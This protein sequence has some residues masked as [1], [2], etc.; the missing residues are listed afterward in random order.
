M[1][2]FSHYVEL[3]TYFV[4]RLFW[5]VE[6]TFLI[7]FAL[8]KWRTALALPSVLSFGTVSANGSNDHMRD[9]QRTL[10]MYNLEFTNMTEREV[11]WHMDV[12]NA[13]LWQSVL[14]CFCSQRISRLRAPCCKNLQAIPSL[15]N[16]NWKQLTQPEKTSTPSDS[17]ANG[18]STGIQIPPACGNEVTKM[19]WQ[20]WTWKI[21]VLGSLLMFSRLGLD[22]EA[23]RYLKVQLVCLIQKQRSQPNTW[24]MGLTVLKSALNLTESPKIDA[25]T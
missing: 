11:F 19:G 17:P 13:G 14:P 7:L 1:I 24:A 6:L 2:Q 16:A 25:T 4:S 3:T 21:W 8:W 10:L 9:E 15:P 20:A 12:K 18:V 22:L 5:Y 23:P